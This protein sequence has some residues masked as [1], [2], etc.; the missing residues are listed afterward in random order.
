[1]VYFM[2][3]LTNI[4]TQGATKALASIRF[5]LDHFPA[6]ETDTV[7]AF[8]ILEMAAATVSFCFGVREVSCLFFQSVV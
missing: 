3:Q 6:S 5:L 1:M 4:S 8:V 7:E 2:M